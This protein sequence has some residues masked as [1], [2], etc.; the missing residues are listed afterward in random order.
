MDY[1]LKDCGAIVGYAQFIF[2]R[3]ILRWE[4]IKETK[5]VKRKENTLSTNKATKKRKEKTLTTKE[6]R[7]EN[8]LSIKKKER[9]QE[10]DQEN[11]NHDLNQEKNTF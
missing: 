6:K 10:L 1:T 3:I 8:T 4:F 7:K 11:R 5:K 9:K 2:L